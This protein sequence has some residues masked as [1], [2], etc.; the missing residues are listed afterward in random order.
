M[1][2]QG[3]ITLGQIEGELA[4]NL[5]PLGLHRILHQHVQK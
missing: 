4:V 1:I 2:A 3:G 5:P